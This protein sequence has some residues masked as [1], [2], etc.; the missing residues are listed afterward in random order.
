MTVLVNELKEGMT[1]AEDMYSNDGRLLLAKDNRI[2]AIQVERIQN[3]HKITGAI[4]G[5]IYVYQK[6]P[7][8]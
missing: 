7:G 4:G 1:L 8:R 2:S 3:Y 6:T 5:K